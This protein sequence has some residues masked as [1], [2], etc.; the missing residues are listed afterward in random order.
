LIRDPYSWMQSM[1][2]HSYAANW[3]HRLRCPNLVV[4]ENDRAVIPE[5]QNDTFA[6]TIRYPIGKI[7]WPSLADVWSDWYN[8]YLQADYP[9]LIVRFE[10]LIF[11]QKKLIGTICECAGAVP[12]TDSFSYVVGAGKWG[13]SH[14]GSSNMVSA[15][16]KYGSDK[17]RFAHLTT[18]DLA[19]ASKHVDANLLHLFH[20]NTADIPVQQG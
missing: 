19:F 2:K 8:Q 4:T 18:E 11:Q 1:C 7:S 13:K 5:A 14:T 3:F 20:Y 17:K 12:K 6:V 10:D 16:I 9:R 15:M